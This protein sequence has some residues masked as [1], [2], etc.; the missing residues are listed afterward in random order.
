M[1]YGISRLGKSHWWAIAHLSYQWELQGDQITSRTMPKKLP[2]AVEP[3]QTYE[4]VEVGDPNCGVL[5]IKKR[6]SLAPNEQ[7]YIKKLTKERELPDLKREAVKLAQKIARDM[8]ESVVDVHNALLAGDT[9]MLGDYLEDVIAFQDM[10]DFVSLERRQILATT[11]LKF[12][13]DPEWTLDYSSDADI[14]H[15][16]LVLALALFAANEENGW[17]AEEETPPE[18]ATPPTDED[19]GKS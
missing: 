4:E 8:G 12:R 1:D 6:G 17:P 13:I 9:A 2:Y 14:I 19:L 11:M 18:P 15:P 7:G 10:M 5:H 3:Q 16:D